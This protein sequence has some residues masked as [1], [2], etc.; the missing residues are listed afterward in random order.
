MIN[1]S[2]APKL[3]DDKAKTVI[4]YAWNYFDFHAKQRIQMFNFFILIFGVMAS[5]VGL[6]LGTAGYKDLAAVP[7]YAGAIFSLYDD[8][9]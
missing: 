6:L 7:L 5:A 8:I 4:S 2:E 3:D 9:G 1:Q